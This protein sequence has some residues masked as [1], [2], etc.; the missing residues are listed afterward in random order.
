M[1]GQLDHISFGQCPL[2]IQHG[3]LVAPSMSEYER[4]KRC[5]LLPKFR[6]ISYRPFK[7]H[8]RVQ[9]N[10]PHDISQMEPK[11]VIRNRFIKFVISADAEWNHMRQ[12][13]SHCIDLPGRRCSSVSSALLV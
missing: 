10:G 13:L 1:L 4:W 2:S 5:D 12:I 11:A 8:A 7:T 6:L 9:Q 3:H